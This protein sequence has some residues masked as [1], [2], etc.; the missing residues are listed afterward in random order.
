MFVELKKEDDYKKLIK[1]LAIKNGDV[2]PPDTSPPKSEKTETMSHRSKHVDDSDSDYETTDSESGSESGYESDSDSCSESESESGSDSES[3]SDQ[4][5][6]EVDVFAYKN[7]KELTKR[8]NLIIGMV[9][10][11]NYSQDLC[12]EGKQINDLLLQHKIIDQ[13][14]HKKVYKFFSSHSAGSSRSRR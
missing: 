2:P 4:E 3:D 12:S 14:E 10:A 7:P 1:H 13:T 9:N 8:M 5:G 11:G 6:G